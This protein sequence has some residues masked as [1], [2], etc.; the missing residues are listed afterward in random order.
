MIAFAEGVDV[1][2]GAGPD[3]AERCCEAGF[4]AYEI[5]RSCQFHIGSIA[6]KCR[7]RQSCPFGERRIVGEIVAAV[8][9]RTA[10]RIEDHVE[11][12]RLRCLRDPQLGAIGRRDRRRRTHRPV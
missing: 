12:K 7:N 3:V 10:M 5:F 6:F 1:V 2:A 4:L 9:R 8:A 11:T